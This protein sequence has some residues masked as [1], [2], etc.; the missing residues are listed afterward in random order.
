[1]AISGNQWPGSISKLADAASSSIVEPDCTSRAHTTVRP[2][3]FPPPSIPPQTASS[4]SSPLSTPFH[5]YVRH[6]FILA[7][8]FLVGTDG[9]EMYE[10]VHN[11][12]MLAEFETDI[13][14]ILS[15]D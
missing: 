11:E 12:Q 5:L 8:L 9:T 6:T 2:A 10:T 7:E 14:G 4:K 15:D 13:V 1:M 3:S